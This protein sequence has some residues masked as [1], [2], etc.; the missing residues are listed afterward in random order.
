MARNL[1]ELGNRE[2]NLNLQHHCRVQ[3]GA[4]PPPQEDE[5]EKMLEEKEENMLEE[6]LEGMDSKFCCVDCGSRF[7]KHFLYELHRAATACAS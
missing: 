3:I 6:P 7:K 4:L 1:F 5:E 2:I